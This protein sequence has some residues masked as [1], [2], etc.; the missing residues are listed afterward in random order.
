M[1]Y[2]F[3]KNKEKQLK[4]SKGSHSFYRFWLSP[5]IV[6]EYWDTDS[7]VSLGTFDHESHNK[8]L[9][10]LNYVFSKSCISMNQN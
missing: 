6:T 9:S 1:A 2:L 10:L 7:F 5:D 8:T 3:C 4:K